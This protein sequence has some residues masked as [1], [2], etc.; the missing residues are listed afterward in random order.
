[1]NQDAIPNENAS[2]EP[3]LFPPGSR[4]CFI[5]TQEKGLTEKLV[6]I[7]ESQGYYT[8]TADDP[9]QGV[10]KLRLNRYDVAVVQHN[11]SNASMFEEINSWPGNTR[12]AMNLIV[13]GGEAPSMH[14]SQSLVLGAN[15]Y[16]NIDDSDNLEELIMQ[17][18]RGYQ[19]YYHPWHKVLEE[20]ND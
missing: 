13:L 17:C 15:F 1:M 20:M 9:G 16:L 19:L 5:F 6:T 8:A 18:L 4:T 11:S 12:R 3:D 7:F 2:V 14:Q 10:A